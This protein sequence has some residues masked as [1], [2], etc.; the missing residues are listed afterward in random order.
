MNKNSMKDLLIKVLNYYAATDKDAVYARKGLYEKGSVPAVD[1]KVWGIE[2]YKSSVYPYIVV[3]GKV[4][5]APE[6]YNDVSGK[7]TADYQNYL[8]EQ[9]IKS[10][11][12]KYKV[13]INK[14][15]LKT[16]K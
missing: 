5:D 15:V 14:D 7:V 16:I 4:L 12:A 2:G 8:D 10:L 3:R 13:E 9:W 6:E 1:L 11:R